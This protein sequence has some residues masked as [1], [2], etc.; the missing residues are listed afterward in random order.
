MATYEILKAGVTLNDMKS[1][2]EFSTRKKIAD[3]AGMISFDKDEK[4]F[5]WKTQ[6]VKV[7]TILEKNQV[8]QLDSKC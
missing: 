8:F 5:L 2:S 4:I 6:R 3:F 1:L 7:D